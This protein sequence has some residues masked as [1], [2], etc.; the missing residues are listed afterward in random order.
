MSVIDHR[1]ASGIRIVSGG[2]GQS[3]D[4]QAEVL[5]HLDPLVRYIAERHRDRVASVAP[6]VA[7][8]RAGLQSV[9]TEIAANPQSR[10][11][12]TRAVRAILQAVRREVARQALRPNATTH[13][14]VRRAVGQWENVHGRSPAVSELADLL[15]LPPHRILGDLDQA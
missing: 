12:L 10:D 4:V 6:L 3:R 7:A 15:R 2:P 8:G 1:S 5:H 14:V 13:E 11:S 9:A